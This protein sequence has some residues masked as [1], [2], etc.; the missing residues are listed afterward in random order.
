LSADYRCGYTALN[1][2]ETPLRQE[3]TYWHLRTALLIIPRRLVPNRKAILPLDGAGEFLKAGM[4]G[5]I[6]ML[7]I[8]DR[9][10]PRLW[11]NADVRNKSD[12]SQSS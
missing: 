11:I 5:D 3:T 10:T 7:S 12:F 9:P 6:K 8:L 2:L 1:D 4:V